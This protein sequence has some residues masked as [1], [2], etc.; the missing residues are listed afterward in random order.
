M[1]FILT[2]KN[3]ISNFIGNN[4]VDDNLTYLRLTKPFN[5]KANNVGKI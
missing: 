1:Y 5:F 4:M 3:E 2:Y